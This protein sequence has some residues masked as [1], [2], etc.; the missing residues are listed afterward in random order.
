MGTDQEQ[1]SATFTLS[2]IN[3]ILYWVVSKK[4][5]DVLFADL[6]VPPGLGLMATECHSRR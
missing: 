4:A 6:F 2:R 1:V 5:Y 3:E